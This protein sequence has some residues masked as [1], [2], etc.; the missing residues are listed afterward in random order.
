MPRFQSALTNL[1]DAEL[2]DQANFCH[3]FTCADHRKLGEDLAVVF[4][5]VFCDDETN[6]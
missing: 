4:Y 3:H 2:Y 1:T 5:K 6:K